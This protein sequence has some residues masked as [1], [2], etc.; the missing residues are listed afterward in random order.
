MIARAKAHYEQ[1][2][3]QERCRYV[4]AQRERKKLE[5]L[6]HYGKGGKLMC[7]WR[8][9]TVSDV[10]MLSLDH[11]KDD[12]VKHR[13]KLGKKINGIHQFG[14]KEIYHWVIINGFPKGLQTLCMNHQWKKQRI[15]NRAER[16][17]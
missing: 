7:C 9:C 11:I 1:K 16:L 15:K 8:G 12:G 13:K 14:G 4:N 6:T 5:A 10:D 3:P 2:T 17:A